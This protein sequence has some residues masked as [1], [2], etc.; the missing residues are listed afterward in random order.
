MGLLSIDISLENKINE[1]EIIY[2]AHGGTLHDI[3]KLMVKK[4][5]L[6]NKGLLN[7]EQRYWMN[8]HPTF[9]FLILEDY[10]Y[11]CVKKI[12]ISHHQYYFFFKQKTA[13]EILA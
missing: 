6:G 10:K 13:Y 5:V 8:W 2:T 12:V 7:E 4:E 3:G 1:K 9:G 11:D